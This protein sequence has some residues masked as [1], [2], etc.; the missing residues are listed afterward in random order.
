MNIILNTKLLEEYHYC[1]K[2]LARLLLHF[3]VITQV[4]STQRTVSDNNKFRRSHSVNNSCGL[5]SKS[6]RRLCFR[7]DNNNNTTTYKAP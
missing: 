1:N 2:K 7:D 6:N 3:S 4:L 5:T